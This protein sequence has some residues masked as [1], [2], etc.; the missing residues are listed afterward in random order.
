MPL[1]GHH[2]E[3]VLVGLAKYSPFCKV[4]L[5]AMLSFTMVTVN[6]FI[7]PKKEQIIVYKC[8]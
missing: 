8:Y 4:L 1:N 7:Q 6:K 3:T 5:K 2:K